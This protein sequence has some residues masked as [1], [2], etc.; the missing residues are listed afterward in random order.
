M[1]GEVEQGDVRVV[2]IEFADSRLQ[3][4]AIDQIAGT[5][6]GQE[7][8][9]SEVDG[10]VGVALEHGLHRVRVVHAPAEVPD[11]LV[12]VDTDDQGLAHRRLRLRVNR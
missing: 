11:F 12:M 6:A 10:A 3:L 4:L 2:G 1:P 9:C 7:L 5:G 8:R